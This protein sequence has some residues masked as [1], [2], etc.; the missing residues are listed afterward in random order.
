MFKVQIFAGNHI[1]MGLHN[2]NLQPLVCKD[3][4]P[5]LM[6]QTCRMEMIESHNDEMNGQH[7]GM[8]K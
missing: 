6:I 1:E 2:F 8:L 7:G 5:S 4:S 3:Y